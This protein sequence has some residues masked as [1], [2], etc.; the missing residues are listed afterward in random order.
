MCDDKVPQSPTPYLMELYERYHKHT[1][2]KRKGKKAGNNV[3]LFGELCMAITSYWEDDR[4]ATTMAS[5]NGWPLEIDFESLPDRI[6]KLKAEITGVIANEFVLDH[7]AAWQTF[8]EN[9][10]KCECNLYKFREASDWG[11][12]HS[13]GPNAHAG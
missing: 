10:K 1:E 5:D 12:F 7:S 13:V 4:D 2:L 6:V 8:V 9:L 3:H 11:K